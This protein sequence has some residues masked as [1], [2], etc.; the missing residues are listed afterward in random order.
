M[1]A[2]N[3]ANLQCTI[4]QYWLIVGINWKLSTMFEKDALRVF[5][6]VHDSIYI[7]S[8][9]TGNASYFCRW[10]RNYLIMSDAE[11]IPWRLLYHCISSCSY[12]STFYVRKR[13][14]CRKLSVQ[15]AVYNLTCIVVIFTSTYKMNRHI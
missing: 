3:K 6:L 2:G 7:S 13:L 4:D 11:H 5:Q 1:E 10:W 14:K 8:K 9:I 15:C 12:L